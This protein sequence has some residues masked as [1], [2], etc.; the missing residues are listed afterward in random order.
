M[1]KTGFGTVEVLILLGILGALGTFGWWSY[2]AGQDAKQV[3][4][5][6]ATAMQIEAGQKR[7]AAVSLALLEADKGRA[8]A[9][10]QA[11]DNERKWKEAKREA[12][13]NRRPLVVHTP[14][15]KPGAT[16]PDGPAVNAGAGLRPSASAGVDPAPRAAPGVR[17]TWEFV[18]ALDSAWTGLD[19]KPVSQAA[20]GGDAA[21]R[22]GASPYTAEDVRDVVA[23]NFQACSRDRRQF[24]AMM[25]SVESAADAWDRGR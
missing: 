24:K 9:E 18:F 15:S 6:K 4:W 3:E 19:G 8:T 11:Q 7:A 1:R 17:F 12:D 2:S 20:L 25:N 5:D 10:Q 23:E 13:R 21:F 14:T 22:A 16:E